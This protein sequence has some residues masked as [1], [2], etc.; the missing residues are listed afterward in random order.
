MEYRISRGC[1][2]RRWHE[3]ITVKIMTELFEKL[4]AKAREIANLTLAD[5]VEDPDLLTVALSLTDLKEIAITLCRSQKDDMSYIAA[6]QA[7]DIGWK[8]DLREALIED[9][10]FA[11]GIEGLLELATKVPDAGSRLMPIFGEVIS[12]HV[13]IGLSKK[14]LRKVK[15]YMNEKKDSDGFAITGFN[16]EGKAHITVADWVANELFP[17]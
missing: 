15:T 17:D 3:R 2:T 9:G 7:L 13:K 10:Y 11:S 4:Q 6:H 16:D 12:E 5:V 14:L 8:P 1:G